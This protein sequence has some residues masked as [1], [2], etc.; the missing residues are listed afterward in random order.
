MNGNRFSLYRFLLYLEKQPVP[1]LTV[2]SLA[3]VAGLGWID[4]LTGFELS[5]SFFYLIPVSVSTWGVGR[6]TGIAISALSAITWAVSNTFAGETYPSSFILIWNA[7][8]RLGFFGV[9][10]TLLHTLKQVI[11]EEK[12]LAS[13]DPLTGAYNRRA[14]Y[15]I[16]NT[17]VLQAKIHR[18]PYTLAYIDLD[19]FKQINDQMGHI[20]GDSVL[21]TVVSTIQSNIRDKD[22]IAR[23]GGDEFALLITETDEMGAKHIIERLNTKILAAMQVQGWKI[24]FSI[25]MLTFL[26]PPVR[27]SKMIGLTDQL[28][29]EVK[30]QSKNAMIFSIY[31]ESHKTL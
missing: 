15:E 7:L 1:T 30:S 14:F 24:T 5:F 12:I 21:K 28:M 18:R 20:V 2:V 16:I 27:I 29:Y 11:K 25:G 6:N 23:L 10:T 13:T 19:N 4:Y 26:T 22:F 17:K 3:L 31:D 9:V 8:T